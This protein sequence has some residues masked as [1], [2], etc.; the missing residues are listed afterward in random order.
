MRP[1]MLPVIN[2]GIKEDENYKCELL[3]FSS[4]KNL[5][6]KYSKLAKVQ[7]YTGSELNILP[8]IPDNKLTIP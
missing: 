3:K 4:G 8:G 2:P 1:K 7:V 6:L 5:V